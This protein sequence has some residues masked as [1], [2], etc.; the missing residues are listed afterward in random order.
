MAR[1]GR[2]I[3]LKL[4][5]IDKKALQK[6]LDESVKGL[7]GERESV[8]PKEFERARKTLRGIQKKVR[9]ATANQDFNVSHEE[10]QYLSMSLERIVENNETAFDDMFFI[11]RWLYKLLAKNYQHLY[12]IIRQKRS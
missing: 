10:Y 8:N 3:T 12:A 1:M 7:D 9:K 4:G 5:R 11:K 2:V 6:F